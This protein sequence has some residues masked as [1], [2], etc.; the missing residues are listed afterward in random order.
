MEKLA[1]ELLTL[2]AFFACTD[3]G[4]TGCT[5]ALVSKRIRAASRPARFYSVALFGSPEKIEQFL[6]CYEAER[7]RA[8]EALPRVRH[9][10]L[11]LF[12]KGL[13]TSGGSSTPPP[14]AS[15]RAVPGPLS[16]GQPMSRAEFFA[17][18]QRRT[19]HWRSTQDNLD[20]HYNRVVPTLIRAVAADVKTLALIQAQWRCASVVRCAFPSLRELTVVGGDPTF[21]PFAFVPSGRPLYPALKRLHHILAFVQKDVDMLNWAK[22]APNVTHLRVSR[23]DYHPRITVDSLNEVISET[24]SEE[25]F[26]HLQQVMIQPHPAPPPV[27]ANTTAHLAFRDFLVYLQR[28]KE[29]AKV[30]VAVLPPLEIP[31]MVPGVD[32]HRMCILRVKHEWQER[33]EADGAGCWEERPHSHAMKSQA[34]Q[35]H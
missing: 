18:M 1:V 25:Y 21:L 26:P 22:H 3:G 31:K 12:G 10:C 33:I 4:P 5:L 19:Q 9:L 32:P 14:T 30:P 27:R 15:S 34:Q 23:V 7:A 6:S 11:S 24:A 2:I 29:R 35:S 20:E 17:A 16:A 8:T 28:I 13:D